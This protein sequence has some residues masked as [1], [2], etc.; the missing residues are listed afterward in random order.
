MTTKLLHNSGEMTNI[1]HL[2]AYSKDVKCANNHEYI[3]TALTGAKIIIFSISGCMV[4]Y[5]PTKQDFSRLHVSA[6][7]E[8]V[9]TV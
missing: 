6:S 8:I 5:S 7:T 1:T 9:Y 3:D 2:N 4:L